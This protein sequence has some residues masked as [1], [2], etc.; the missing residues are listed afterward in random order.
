MGGRLYALAHGVQQ[1]FAHFGVAAGAAVRGVDAA[2]IERLDACGQRGSVAAALFLC[3]EGAAGGASGGGSDSVNNERAVLAGC[4]G[5]LGAGVEAL[6]LLVGLE[7]IPL[8][9]DEAVDA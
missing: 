5:G 1:K 2:E 9:C 3:D 6:S 4:P 8:V 7:V